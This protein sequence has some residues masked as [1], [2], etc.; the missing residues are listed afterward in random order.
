MV[1]GRQKSPS[2]QR[3]EASHPVV[4]IRVSRELYQQLNEARQQRGMSWANLVR[5]G[6][7][8]ELDIK[9]AVSKAYDAGYQDG[10]NKREAEVPL[11]KLFKDL[12]K[13]G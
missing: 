9:Q 5:L 8:R 11:G 10:Y 12:L 13:G 6:V 2:R 7:E 4:A 3:Y 1:K